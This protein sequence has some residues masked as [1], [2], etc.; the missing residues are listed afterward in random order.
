MAVGRVN[1]A[2]SSDGYELVDV[3]NGNNNHYYVVSEVY[4]DDALIF[5]KEGLYTAPK[6]K[7]IRG[8]D[9]TVVYDVIFDTATNYRPILAFK[10]LSGRYFVITTLNDSKRI[11]EINPANG[12][13]IRQKSVGIFDQY[14]LVFKEYFLLNIIDNA[15][16][17]LDLNNFSEQRI[18]TSQNYRY[19]PFVLLGDQIITTKPSFPNTSV[20]LE[21]NQQTNSVSV[22]REQV[23]TNPIS[24][25]LVTDNSE[26]Y[27]TFL[28]NSAD[29]G[30]Y[31]TVE[32]KRDGTLIKKSRENIQLNVI[33]KNN[34][35]LIY[36][37]SI[38]PTGNKA[39]RTITLL[40]NKN[41]FDFL[42]IFKT[43]IA[44]NAFF[45]APNYLSIN[46]VGKNLTV[47]ATLRISNSGD[48]ERY[49]IIK[50]KG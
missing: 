5:Y 25:F 35:G 27:I 14:S 11:T 16:I 19:S 26:R 39:L 21:V 9:N 43:D 45:A 50:L 32:N 7:L 15:V 38:S 48:L 22:I 36:N 18:N 13:V 28:A 33:N 40:N 12:S 46:K 8:S 3:F 31:Q 47:I 30:F 49:Q 23:F 6:V 2:S 20:F 17:I 34:L 42:P 4:N 10:A 44:E 24:R 29:S 1:V 37:T 41:T